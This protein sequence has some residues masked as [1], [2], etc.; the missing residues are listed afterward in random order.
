MMSPTLVQNEFK[1]R[2]LVDAS[3]CYARACVP[4]SVLWQ[5]E[6]TL[7][8]ISVLALLAKLPRTAAQTTEDRFQLVMKAVDPVE[9]RRG[10]EDVLSEVYRS[11]GDKGM[12]QNWVYVP[13]LGALQAVLLRHRLM[14]P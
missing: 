5:G 10:V 2:S 1:Q 7:C 11:C 14:L 13:T 6:R 9:H 12:A 3:N 8:P 4:P